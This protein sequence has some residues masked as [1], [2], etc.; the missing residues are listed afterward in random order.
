MRA[1]DGLT[2]LGLF[3]RHKPDLVILDLMLPGLP[4][5]DLFDR[6][7]REKPDVPIIILTAAPRRG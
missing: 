2:A 4:G 1:A 7:R 3:R 5:H 6:M